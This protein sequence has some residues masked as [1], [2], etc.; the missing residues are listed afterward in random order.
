[1]LI[2]QAHWR[3][4]WY[5]LNSTDGGS[6]GNH[7]IDVRIDE[8][9]RPS[10]RSPFGPGPDRTCIMIPYEDIAASVVAQADASLNTRVRLLQKLAAP[11]VRQIQK[12][13]GQSGPLIFWGTSGNVDELAHAEIVNPAILL[14]LL[15]LAGQPLSAVNPHAGVQHTYGYLFSTIQTP[16]GKKRDRWTCTTLENALGLPAD[17]LSPVPKSGTLL[18]NATWV[19]G[20]I[21]FANDARCVWLERCLKRRVP[22]EL[23]SLDWSA[24]ESLRMTESIKLPKADRH[25]HLI[26]DLVRLNA[27]PRNAAASPELPA[28]LLVYSIHDERVGHPEL[29]TLFTVREEFVTAI[30]ERAKTRRRSDIR[31]RYNAVVAN[32]PMQ[33]MSGTVKLVRRTRQRQSPT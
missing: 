9:R 2:Q 3:K 26:T 6:D 28:W 17:T 15:N 19:A 13:R 24:R 22:P 8:K 30:Q 10:G 21:A 5:L 11:I 27:G 32:I 29:I 31:L 1:M 23:H 7:T 12:D 14:P 25:L 18:A 20:R 4:F 16:F 33:E